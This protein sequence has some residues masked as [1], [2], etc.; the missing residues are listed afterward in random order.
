MRIKRPFDANAVVRVHRDGRKRVDGD[1]LAEWYAEAIAPDA[2]TETEFAAYDAL[3]A[4]ASRQFDDA[5][6]AHSCNRKLNRGFRY[7][8]SKESGHRLDVLK[9]SRDRAK[10]LR[11]TTR[12]FEPLR[13][14][15]LSLHWLGLHDRE[16][17]ELL[18][19]A[20]LEKRG[21]CDETARQRVRA[22]IIR[23]QRK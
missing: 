20:D 19:A 22:R 3:E 9:R 23:A 21:V 5:L 18:D 17:V 13:A 6:L 16:I 1:H 15:C 7:R 2:M 8:L 12:R 14:L 10:T 11:G 4:F